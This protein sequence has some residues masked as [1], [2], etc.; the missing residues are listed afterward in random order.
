M[1]EDK[2]EN[3]EINKN[4][5]IS[6]PLGSLILLIIIAFLFFFTATLGT[7]CALKLFGII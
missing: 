4:F 1:K 3:I 6:I 7:L 5:K 2:E